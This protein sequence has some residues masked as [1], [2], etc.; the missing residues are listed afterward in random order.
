M[1]TITHALMMSFT[2]ALEIFWAL[3]LGFTLSAVVKAVVSKEEI[4]RLLPDDRPGA[5][6]N[7]VPKNCF[8]IRP[9]KNRFGQLSAPISIRLTHQA[10]K[11]RTDFLDNFIRNLHANVRDFST[12]T[13]Q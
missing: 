13:G 9:A 10:F 1:S 8:Q 4:S 12:V 6:I 2:M 5:I 11:S 7:A 3:T